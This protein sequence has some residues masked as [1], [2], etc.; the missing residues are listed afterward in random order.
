VILALK[1]R[2]LC[3]PRDLAVAGFGDE[4]IASL[5]KPSLTALDLDSHHIGQQA[6]RL[7]LERIHQKEF[8]DP[9]LV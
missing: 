1:Q 5:L 6:A 3:V 4:Y 9:A 2:K 8:F 7:F